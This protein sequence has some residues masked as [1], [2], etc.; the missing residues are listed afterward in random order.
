MALYFPVTLK[1]TNVIPGQSRHW[2]ALATPKHHTGCDKFHLH[3]F[4]A[5]SIQ[6]N[7]LDLYD[8]EIISNY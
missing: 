1:C 4:T 5:T 2:A 3:I 8:M 6:D 7:V